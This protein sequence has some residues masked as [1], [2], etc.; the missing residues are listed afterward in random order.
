MGKPFVDVAVLLDVFF[1]LRERGKLQLA[2][3]L[4]SLAPPHTHDK[5]F[6]NPDIHTPP[7]TDKTG[8][9][10]SG[11]GEKRPSVFS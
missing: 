2:T 11:E 4:R 1:L 6:A 8:E 5:R 7:D 3:P 10:S 9:E